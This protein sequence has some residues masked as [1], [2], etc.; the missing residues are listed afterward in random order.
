LTKS[1]PESPYEAIGLSSAGKDVGNGYR[2]FDSVTYKSCDLRRTLE[3][4]FIVVIAA[5]D[6]DFSIC[7]QHGGGIGTA[8]NL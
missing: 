7:K 3:T 5:T 8:V 6:M 4:E 2:I 1:K